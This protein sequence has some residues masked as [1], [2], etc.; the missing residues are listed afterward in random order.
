[1]QNLPH[2]L[3]DLLHSPVAAGGLTA[4]FTNLLLPK[5]MDDEVEAQ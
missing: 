5:F 4:I 3:G 1:V 2:W